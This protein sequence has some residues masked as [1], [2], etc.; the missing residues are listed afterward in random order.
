MF[1]QLMS[2]LKLPHVKAEV[3]P[4]QS[5]PPLLLLLFLLPFNT[6][7]H[8]VLL[9]LASHWLG[10]QSLCRQSGD[11]SCAQMGAGYPQ[12]EAL[13]MC[14]IPTGMRRVHKW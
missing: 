11:F 7:T 9:Q 4:S 14:F 10:L 6:F 13:L 8:F 2:W 1:T 3:G 5:Q 12:E